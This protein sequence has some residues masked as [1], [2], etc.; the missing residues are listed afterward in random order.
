MN[1]FKKMSM[2]IAGGVIMATSMSF[3]APSKDGKYALT[4]GTKLNWSAAKVTAT[5][6]G[7]VQVKSGNVFIKGGIVTAG[8]IVMNM[9]TINCTDMGG[10]YG[11]KF[12]G[13]LN[14]DDFFSVEKFK[15]SKLVITKYKKVNANTVTLT[16]NLT[17]KGVSKPVTF[18][19]T[20][21]PSGKKDVQV[22]GTM[23]VDRTL[24][25]ITY[26]GM[27]DNLIK[28]NFEIQFDFTASAQ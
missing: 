8:T 27:A 16:G 6:T 17:I 23:V 13:H 10:E 12:E 5:H 18:D 22:K 21:E 7:T 9:E 3:L 28:D 4:A 24:Y 1:L 14:S 2:I 20:V 19:A 25:G 15:E 11:K 26:K